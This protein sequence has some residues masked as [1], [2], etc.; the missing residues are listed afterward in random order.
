MTGL[1]TEAKDGVVDLATKIILKSEALKVIHMGNVSLR[2]SEDR[3]QNFCSFNP[4][5]N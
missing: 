2:L 3:L 5:V 1:V 4:V